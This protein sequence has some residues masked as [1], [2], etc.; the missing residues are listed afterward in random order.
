MDTA[1]FS[2]AVLTKL[3]R[4]QVLEIAQ[5]RKK[6][7]V[8]IVKEASF[9]RLKVLAELHTITQLQGNSKP[10]LSIILAGQNN[11][12]Y[13]F[14]YRTFLPLASRVVARSHLAGASLQDMQAYLLH[15]LN[16]AGVEQNLFSDPA[17]TAIQQN[18]GDLFRRAN[19]LA[20][21]AITAAAE[22]QTQVVSPEHVRIA[23][24]ELI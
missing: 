23:A 13:L 20:R 14:I 18:S 15:H 17:V 8:L 10:I 21:G 12:A 7:P 24:A 6:S 1:S 11:L 5:D 2:R 9:L 22:G 16:I 19:H 3:I 4:K